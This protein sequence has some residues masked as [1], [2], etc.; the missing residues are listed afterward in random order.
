MSDFKAKMHLNRF[1]QLRTPLGE[2]T[3]HPQF[4]QT[5]SWNKR[6]LFLREGRIQEG[7]GQER[8][9]KTEGKRKRGEGMRGR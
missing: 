8:E 9:G 3:E 7:E 1:R 4:P 5:P 6:D 2:L